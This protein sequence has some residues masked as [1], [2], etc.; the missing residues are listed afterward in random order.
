LLLTGHSH[1]AW[2]DCALAGQQQAWHDAA[3]HV[4]EKWSRAFAQADRVRRGYADLLGEQPP[5]AAGG[6]IALAQNTHELVVRLL[7]ALPLTR[8]PRIVTTDGE[9]HTIRRQLDRLAEEGIEI[10]R[11]PAHPHDGIADRL[12]ATVD[13]RTAIVMVSTVLFG[14]AL[15]VPGLDRVLAACQRVGAQLLVDTYHHLAVVPF[16][17]ADAGLSD[18][19]IVG[20]GYKYCQ[21][22]EG[23][24]F[25]RFPAEC[26]LRPIVTGWFSE[27]ASV[28]D[29]PAATGVV[30]GSGPARFAGATYEPTSHYRAAEVFDYFERMGL[31]A[32]FLRQ[33]SQHQV[34]VLAAAFD[35]LDADPQVIRRDRSTSLTEIGGFLVL[36]SARAGEICRR[37]RE[38]EVFTD[39]RGDALR[40]GPA[41]Y[42][43]DQQLVAA[44]AILGEIVRA[45]S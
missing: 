12:G 40:L 9:F 11:V 13:E 29:S 28:A 26:E 35:D 41:P 36:R 22:G 10:V 18:A 14:S 5:A 42:L 33:V 7:S 37:L 38:R 21:L 16:S 39:F 6:H 45:L 34:G 27:F 8:R 31:T 1:Q 25:L 2:P 43:A 20:G 32:G 44:V 19:F 17:I 23:N 15:I 3:E 4:D 24:C 30:Y